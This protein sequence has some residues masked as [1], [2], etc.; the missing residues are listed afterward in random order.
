M[1]GLGLVTIWDA[2][3]T[4]YGTSTI[5]GNGGIQMMLS[6]L[7]GLLLAAFLIR[8]LPII[9]NPDNDDI[10]VVGGK[11]LWFLAILYDLF[12]SFTGNFDLILGTVEGIQKTIMA[13][14][15]TL[16]VSSAP[17]GLSS[18]MYSDKYKY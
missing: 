1:I 15:L 18:V 10:I 4:V 13:I 14:G 5:I 2:A 16:F 17:I 3:T 12:T 11:V 9:K 6:V 7:F 8:T